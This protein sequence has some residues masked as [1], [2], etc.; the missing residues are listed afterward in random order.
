[1]R[2]ENLMDLGLQEVQ[3]QTKR[4]KGTLPEPKAVSIAPTEG[5]HEDTTLH[6]EWEPSEIE[7][8]IP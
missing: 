5:R 6:H 8:P 3:S 4:C 2:R 1:M 7:K